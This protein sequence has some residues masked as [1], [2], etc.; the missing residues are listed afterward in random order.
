ME[1]VKRYNQGF[2]G[3]GLMEQCDDGRWVCAE[4]YDKLVRSRDAYHESFKE[5]ANKALA[6]EG[7]VATLKR[8]LAVSK[9][10]A[11]RAVVACVIS[12]ALLISALVS[13]TVS[14]SF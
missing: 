12:T 4:D 10:E 13:M 5:R 14:G 7:E 8:E 6:L 3:F 2:G 11:K 9:F 1:K